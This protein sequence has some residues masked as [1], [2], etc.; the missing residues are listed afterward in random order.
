MSKIIDYKIVTKKSASELQIQV[1]DLIKNEDWTPI[2][3]HQVVTRESYDQY[4]G[5]QHRSVQY[6]YEYSQT[7]V[8]KV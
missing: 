6:K 5:N 4:A 1:I 2:G 8:K 7:L 3:S